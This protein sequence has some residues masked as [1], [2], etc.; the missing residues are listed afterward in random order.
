MKMKNITSGKYLDYVEDKQKLHIQ[1][2]ESKDGT[3]SLQ[4]YIR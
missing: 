3:L 1:G 2:K 4:L